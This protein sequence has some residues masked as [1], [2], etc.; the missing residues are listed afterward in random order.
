MN[1]PGFSSAWAKKGCS[2]EERN[3]KSYWE[4]DHGFRQGIDGAREFM[5][6]HPK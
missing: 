4:Y 2:V 6:N 5:V 3:K 1:E